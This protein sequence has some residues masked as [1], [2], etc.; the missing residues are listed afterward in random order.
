MGITNH[1]NFR[2][3]RGDIF[4]GVTAA[5]IALP[6]ALAFG[7]ATGAGAASGLYGAVLVGFFAALFGGTPTLISEPT[8]PMTVVFTAVIAHLIAAN[9]ENGMAMAFTVVI[10]AGLFQII[11]GVL[12]LGRYVTLMPYPVISG[13]MSGIGVIL[14]IMQL[15]PFLGQPSPKGGVV[16]TLTSLPE[17]VSNLS[18]PEVALSAFTLLV[19]FFYPKQLKRFVPPQLVVLIAGTVLAMVL[20]S[21]AD[22]RLIGEIPTGLP[23]LQMPVFQADQVQVMLIDGLVL[24][25][26][27]CIDALL[28]AMIADSITRSQSDANKELI[29]QGIGNIASGLFGGMPGAG[30]TMGTV[31]NI[32]AGGKTALSGLVRAG[33]LLVVVLWAAPLTQSIP[34]AVLAGIAVKV[35]FD[36]LDWSFLKRAHNVSWKGTAIMYGV[37]FLTVFVDLIVA[38]GVGVFIANILTI[39]RLT[40]LQSEQVKAITDF[41]EDLPLTDEDKALMDQANGRVL[42]FHLSG[43]MIFGV[44][45]A[46]SQ[47]HTAMAAHDVLIVDLQDVPHLGVTA[48]LALENAIQDASDAGRPVF[49]AGAR[50]KTLSRLEKL[51][52]LRFVPPEYLA[53]N[54]TEAL[55]AALRVLATKDGFEPPLTVVAPGSAAV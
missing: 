48:A 35:G 53:E 13:F 3:V 21:G 41:D 9:P 4:G 42:M 55:R 18:P 29:G 31:V 44:A 40:K 38:V 5:V 33:I 14:I 16:G 24:G 54:R 46:I 32:Q 36:I 17:L 20:F 6:M 51:G 49:L 47:E 19:L 30:A 8:G 26:L 37:M 52:V 34:L 23:S 50:G 7:V 2:N 27:G 12:K 28:T 25:M 15:G 10:L 45:R 39:D 22:L 43:P 1:I 11:F